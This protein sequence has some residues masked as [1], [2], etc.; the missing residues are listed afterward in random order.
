MNLR[1]FKARTNEILA[2]LGSVRFGLLWPNNAPQ[3]LDEAHL[4]QNVQNIGFQNENILSC[5]MRRIWIWDATATSHHSSYFFL[6]PVPVWQCA[7]VTKKMELK[8][9]TSKRSFWKRC[10]KTKTQNAKTKTQNVRFELAHLMIWNVHEAQRKLTPWS[11]S[12]MFTCY[13]MGYLF[14]ATWA[15]R[16]VHT[17]T[18]MSNNDP[19][20]DSLRICS[21]SEA[22]HVKFLSLHAEVLG[23]WSWRRRTILIRT[24]CLLLVGRVNERH[25]RIL[26][27]VWFVSI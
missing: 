11:D 10:F 16:E 12:C 26:A 5:Q 15:W 22:F 14:V 2:A 6:A 1:H 9:H 24:W 27:V 20:C 17:H 18:C 25:C 19:S 8:T 7:H 3:L 21:P 13:A 23:S 4:D